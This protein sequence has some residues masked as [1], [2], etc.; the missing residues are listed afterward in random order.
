[1]AEACARLGCPNPYLALESVD[2][3]KEVWW[4][5]EH[6]DEAAIER[7]GRAYAANPPLLAALNELAAQKNGIAEQP[8][9][10]I[11]KY[12][13]ARSVAVAWRVGSDEFVVIAVGAE[14]GAVF[15]SASLTR[16]AVVST[17][18]LDDARAAA[19]RLG[20]SARI[21]RARPSWSRAAEAWLA[22]NPTLWGKP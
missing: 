14:G 13:S 9:E 15:E 8:V 3:P 12:R 1:M 17:P 5:V 16:L 19:A 6:T 11:M 2:A 21:F 18:S 4:F 10:H 20:S 7:L 22:A